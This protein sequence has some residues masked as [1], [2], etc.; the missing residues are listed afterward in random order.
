MLYPHPD[1]PR[2]DLG[3]LTELADSIKENGVIQNLT[4]VPRK[5]EM[6]SKEYR[7]ACVAYRENPT[8]EGQRILN[9]HVVCEGYTVVIT[10]M[11]FLLNL[12]MRCPMMK[13]LSRMEPMKLFG[14]GGVMDYYRSYLDLP[15]DM[16]NY[17]N[18]C[19]DGKCSGCGECCADL[20]PLTD[21]EVA[22][23]RK[24]AKSHHL[25]ENRH[26]MFFD[27]SATDLT[28]PFRNEKEGK[29]DVY[30]VRPLICREFICSKD[31]QTARHDRNLLHESR[32]PRSL[33]YEIFGNRETLDFLDLA[34]FLSKLL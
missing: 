28:C 15:K 3:D 1:N 18:N 21:K 17:S 5:R 4:V 24:Y 20:L 13:R 23:L 9:R 16:M 12:A 11:H 19:I 27:P 22:D 26:T 33:R 14:G 31:L 6:T 29:C 32:P 10:S 25:K 7:E 34:N 30:P 8:V 2:R